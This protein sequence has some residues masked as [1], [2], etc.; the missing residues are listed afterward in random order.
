MWLAKVKSNGKE[1]FILAI[2]I[3]PYMVAFLYA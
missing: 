3:Q 2:E 1:Q